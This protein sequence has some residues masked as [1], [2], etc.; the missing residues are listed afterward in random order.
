MAQTPR[1]SGNSRRASNEAY[2]APMQN[3]PN[4]Q[5]VQGGAYYTQN[6]TNPSGLT[7]AQKKAR[8]RRKQEMIRRRRRH[9][10]LL[11]AV[12]FLL[13]VGI[14]FFVI[15]ILNGSS[16]APTDAGLDE[17]DAAVDDE[18]EEEKNY[19]G[20]AI[21]TIAFVGDISTSSD[22]VQAVTRSD[23]TY[24]FTQPFQNIESYISGADYA[25]GDFET[26]MVDGLAYGG[27]PYYNSPI[28]LA[29]SLREIGFR[30]MSTAN[31]YMLNNGIDG[32]TST[33]NYLEEAKLKSVGTYLSQEDRDKNGGAYIRTIH[34]IKFAFLAYTKG[35]DSVM[36]PEGCEYA[37]NTLYSDY[38]DYW[39]NL[40][41]T[42]IRA[43]VQAAKD[44]G[45]DV[46]VALVHW[47]SEYG[48]SIS[49]PQQKAAE[50][51]MENGVDVII[52]TH[53]HL[54]GEMG[55]QKVSQT[56]GSTKNCFIAYSLGDFYTDPTD[57]AAQSSVILNITFEKADNGNVT[58]SANYVPI[59]QNIT[60][61]ENGKKSFELLDVYQSIAEIKQ[62]ESVTTAQAK[63][64]NT[65]LDV[66]DT[67]H[68]YAGEELDAGPSAA[69]SRT[70]QN[71]LED[72]AYTAQE[73]KEIREKEQET[74]KE[75]ETAR[76]AAGDTADTEE[77][78]AET[79]T[80]PE[81]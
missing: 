24:D 41:S 40:N 45:A 26:T 66:L 1:R 44:A 78:P 46:I 7:P 77:T 4:M 18:D 39:T 33:K 76:E 57:E 29:G 38:S 67:L 9:R 69:I 6:Q 14:A 42:Q 81:E 64:Y 70:V 27:E 75:A 72:G 19:T 13:V 74:A 52:G 34:K 35:T 30:L 65:L 55:F 47:G 61:D 28:Q 71:A 8:L 59:Y 17:V 63:L 5:N 3:Q 32:L 12:A 53:S 2:H 62:Q 43:D 16:S 25:V 11:L 20:P 73:L 68:N 79:E 23:G 50:L 51:L 56:D 80:D 21:A 60:T 58:M 10:R 54:V 36:M 22:Q 15:R 37:L 48:R 49:E 31:T